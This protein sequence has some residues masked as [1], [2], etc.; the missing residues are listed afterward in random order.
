MLSGLEL[1]VSRSEDGLVLA[2]PKSLSE[3]SLEQS[4]AIGEVDWQPVETLPTRVGEWK[5]IK[6]PISTARRF[7]RLKSP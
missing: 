6:V 4:S 1:Q 2:W 5:Q 7:Y 3:A